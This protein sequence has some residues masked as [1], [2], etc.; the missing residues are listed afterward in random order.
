MQ[1]KKCHCI[2]RTIVIQDIFIYKKLKINNFS[3]CLASLWRY[4]VIKLHQALV[5]ANPD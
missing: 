5:W 2:E 3:K 4:M 1:D